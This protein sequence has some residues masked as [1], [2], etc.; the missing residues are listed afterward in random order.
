[1]IFAILGETLYAKNKLPNILK[2]RLDLCLTLYQPNDKIIV[3]GG[4]VCGRPKCNK[5][6]ALVMRDYLTS[7]NISNKS[8][9]LENRSKSTIHNIKNIMKICVTNRFNNISII[10]SRWHISR[11]KLICNIEL[12]KYIKTKFISTNESVSKKRLQQEK[13]YRYLLQFS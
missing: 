9:I 1:M 4:N 3:C 11:V 6:E 2:N 5:T 8:I 7:N 10:S 13:L 12:P